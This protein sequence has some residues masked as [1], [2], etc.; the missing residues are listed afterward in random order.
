MASAAALDMFDGVAPTTPRV[1][2]PSLLE[3]IPEDKKGRTRRDELPYSQFIVAP[4]QAE[5][6]KRSNLKLK[7]TRWKKSSFYQF[8]DENEAGILNVLKTHPLLNLVRTGLDLRTTLRANGKDK[9]LDISSEHV[10]NFLYA[11]LEDIATKYQKMDELSDNEDFLDFVFL[12]TIESI[13]FSIPTTDREYQLLLIHNVY[14]RM[15][16]Q[17]AL[18]YFSSCVKSFLDKIDNLKT[19]GM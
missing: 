11:K 2:I 14:P 4:P 13:R 7:T 19:D 1:Q 5:V 6:P 12:T 10:Y 3:A 8:I 9:V 18:M 17:G 15:E 16:Q